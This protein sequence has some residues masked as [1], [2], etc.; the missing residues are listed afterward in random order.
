MA[1]RILVPWPRIGPVPPAVDA[2]IP[3]HWTA[4]EFLVFFK[5]KFLTT[6]SE[7]MA[8]SFLESH[9]F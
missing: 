8:A 6:D 7:R 9:D 5:I 2:Q 3:N 4:K 1:C